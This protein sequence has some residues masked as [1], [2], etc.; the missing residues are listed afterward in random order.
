MVLTLKVSI[1][2]LHQAVECQVEDMRYLRMT[3]LLKLACLG[4]ALMMR[5]M[6]YILSRAKELLANRSI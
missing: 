6:R 4:F 3:F 2:K 5:Q 1:Q